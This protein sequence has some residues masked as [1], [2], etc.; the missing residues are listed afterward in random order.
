MRNL[1]RISGIRP[2]LFFVIITGCIP[3]CSLDSVNGPDASESPLPS[4]SAFT[5]WII[6]TGLEHADQR[7]ERC[8]HHIVL[9][10][11][12]TLVA[13]LFAAADLA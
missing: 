13:M 7:F 3:G 10:A 4:A 6:A 12:G 1:L 9:A 5:E 8:V 11:F 2:W